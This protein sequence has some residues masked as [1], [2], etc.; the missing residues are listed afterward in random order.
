DDR[1]AGSEE[2]H[3]TL[4]G[5]RVL[6][7][8]IGE[9]AHE[10]RLAAQSGLARRHGL[11][12]RRTSIRA[13]ATA[14]ERAN[15]FRQRTPVTEQRPIQQAERRGSEDL[16]QLARTGRARPAQLPR[17]GVPQELV[18]AQALAK[19]ARQHLLAQE[20][21]G[22]ELAAGRVVSGLDQ[23]V[24]ARMFETE[25]EGEGPA[26]EA[27]EGEAQ[28]AARG[29]PARHLGVEAALRGSIPDR[30]AALSLPARSLHLEALLEER[31]EPRSRRDL[32]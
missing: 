7:S 19:R 2:F 13:C 5:C 4:E 23:V 17:L 12:L 15:A 9:H 27:Q 25:I 28:P 11:V 30:G 10:V 20:L 32:E 14:G 3:L 16:D 8:V 29:R 26:I 22:T 21:S 24:H 1:M 6:D 18:R 31:V